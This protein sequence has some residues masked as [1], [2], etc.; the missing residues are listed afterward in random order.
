MKYLPFF[1]FILCVPFFAFTQVVNTEKL[2]L[3]DNEKALIGE[4]SLTFGLARNKAGQ[5]LRLGS[6]LR[7]E[8]N[9]KKHRWML[10]GAYHLTQ[11]TN[12]DEAGSVPNIMYTLTNGFSFNF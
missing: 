2:R 1:I 9:Q 6:R 5:T 10:L 4:T 7:L 8:L 12:V 3:A 11:F